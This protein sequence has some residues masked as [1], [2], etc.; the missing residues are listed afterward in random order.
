LEE[1]GLSEEYD[2]ID[3]VEDGVPDRNT[4]RPQQDNSP[5]LKYMKILQ[6]IADRVK[7]QIVVELDDLRAVSVFVAHNW[8]SAD[9][10]IV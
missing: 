4:R 6:E 10:I 1:D 3:D 5:K 9:G 7:D 8:N 2:F